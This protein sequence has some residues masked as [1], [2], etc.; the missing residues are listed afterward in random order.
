MIGTGQKDFFFKEHELPVKV[1]S[2]GFHLMTR[3]QDE[4]HRF[5]IEYHRSLRGREQTK[6]ILDDISGI[7][8][9]RRKA[10]MR[11]FS[12]IEDIRNAT[13]EE[14]AQIES[15]NENAAISV[16]EFFH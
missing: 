1:D 16:Y 9:R 5:A 14:L 7:G 10:L 12:S 2:E 8:E 11:H 6:S 4:V 3:I 15:M 13:V